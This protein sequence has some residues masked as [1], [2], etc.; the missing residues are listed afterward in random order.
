MSYLN[1]DWEAVPFWRMAMAPVEALTERAKAITG[2]AGVGEVIETMA[3][4]G[5]G[6]LPTVEIPSIGITLDGDV[7]QS[8]RERSTP[9]MARVI[10]D[11]TILDLRT[12]DPGDDEG[13]THALQ[14]IA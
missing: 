10:E 6:T 14:S 9:I 3:V 11:K 5:G 1:R 12:V 13:I 7:R 2:A 8:L 4:P